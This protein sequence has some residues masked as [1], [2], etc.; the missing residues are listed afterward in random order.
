M[1][2]HALKTPSLNH[3][4]LKSLVLLFHSDI[5][6]S[7]Q[8]PV[9]FPKF[10]CCGVG[11]LSGV[12]GLFVPVLRANR[13]RDWHLRPDPPGRKSSEM[14][15]LISRTELSG[16]E[17]PYGL[18]RI[19]A[20]TQ[21]LKRQN[22]ILQGRVMQQGGFITAN[23]HI[24]TTKTSQKRN[25]SHSKWEEIGAK[26]IEHLMNSFLFLENWDLTY[27]NQQSFGFCCV[28]S[29]NIHIIYIYM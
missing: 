29:K 9:W 15:I 21:L 16:Q 6:S 23:Y 7:R 2:P 4:H 14:D 5:D 26:H 13:S 10:P 24:Q 20:Q 17:L 18:C 28:C 1:F 11:D 19:S 8:T 22:G 12:G 27:V 3:A 25:A